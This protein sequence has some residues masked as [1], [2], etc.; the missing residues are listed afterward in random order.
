M[1][2][3]LRNRYL[4]SVAF[5]IALFGSA[6]FASAARPKRAT[7]QA[8]PPAPAYDAAREVTIHG[9]VDDVKET[10]LA[11]WRSSAQ[12][13][14]LATPEGPVTVELAPSSFLKARDF[15]CARGDRVELVGSPVVDGDGTVILA[16]ELRKGGAVLLLRDEAG[17]PTWRQPLREVRFLQAGID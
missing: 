8:P 10:L 9:T 17:R 3:R 13:I 1:S 12:R 7:R 16:R 14:V 6:P 2:D 5:L 11:S 4:V 15:S